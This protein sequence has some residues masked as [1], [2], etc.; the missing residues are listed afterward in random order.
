MSHFGGTPSIRVAAA[1]GGTLLAGSVLAACTYEDGGDPQATAAPSVRPARTIPAVAPDVL[2]RQGR[3]TAELD[4]L[5][6]GGP[7][8]VLLTDSGPA[9][10]PSVGFQKSATVKTAGPYLV[11]AACV[12][13]SGV[14]LHLSQPVVGGTEDHAIDVDCSASST[15][16]VQLREGFVGVGLT[17]ASPTGPWTGA[18]A[19]VRITG[20]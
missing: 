5:L 12:G 1:I 6:G 15:S 2:A 20:P 9:D 14:Q 13:L 19:G 4:R 16:V 10:G 17:R 8:T 11:T 18:V 7:G 3:N